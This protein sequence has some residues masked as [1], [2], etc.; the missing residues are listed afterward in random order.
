MTTEK[1]THSDKEQRINQGMAKYDPETAQAWALIMRKMRELRAEGK[2]LEAI[3][4]PMN[5][6]R[7]AVSRWLKE[8]VGGEKN[9]FGDMVRYAK[10]LGISP[11]ELVSNETGP[12]QFVDEYDKALGHIL[13]EAAQD[14][15]ISTTELAEKS[16]ISPEKIQNIFNGEASISTRQLY[17]LCKALE[18]K[19]NVILNRA[20]KL[21]N[22]P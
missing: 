17:Q 1:S 5:V 4:K 19:S 14:D 11:K 16:N 22:N 7:A 9:T 18:I 13:K 8:D 10:A 3:G 21:L 20:M 15:E 2:T 12:S 6:G